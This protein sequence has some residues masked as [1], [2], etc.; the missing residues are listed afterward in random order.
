[1]LD[2]D[3]RPPNRHEVP[4]EMRDAIVALNII[5]RFSQ[6]QIAKALCL[7]Q[8]TISDILARSAA[9]TTEEEGP[10]G[11]FKHLAYPTRPGRPELVPE[12]SKESPDPAATALMDDKHQEMTFPEVA[13]ELGIKAARS[14][15]EKVMHKHHKIYRRS[16][17]LSLP[18][19]CKTRKP[20]QPLLPGP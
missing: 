19:H 3:D 5:T 6:C 4:L 14:T 18:F 17:A 13:Q 1:M 15:L 2:Y 10:L 12:G 16:P 9:Q 8:Q 20:G 7:K 11:Q